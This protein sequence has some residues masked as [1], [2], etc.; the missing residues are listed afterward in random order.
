MSLLWQHVDRIK[1]RLQKITI[2][3]QDRMAFTAFA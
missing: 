2:D 1:E 3:G